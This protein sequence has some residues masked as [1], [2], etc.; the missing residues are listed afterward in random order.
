MLLAALLATLLAHHNAEMNMEANVHALL[1]KYYQLSEENNNE[2][3]AL[4]RLGEDSRELVRLGKPLEE[5]VR[6]LDEPT[7]P[8]NNEAQ[9]L[10]ELHE[11]FGDIP[12][13]HIR[14]PDS[15]GGIKRNM[16]HIYRY[17]QSLTAAN[18]NGSDAARTFSSLKQSVDA[19]FINPSLIWDRGFALTTYT[20]HEY[21]SI[22]DTMNFQTLIDCRMLTSEEHVKSDRV[23]QAIQRLKSRVN[24]DLHNVINSR[25][26]QS[27]RRRCGLDCSQN[28]S[29]IFYK[30]GTTKTIKFNEDFL[31]AELGKIRL[32]LLRLV[33]IK[34]LVGPTDYMGMWG[35]PVA[36]PTEETE[37]D[38]VVTVSPA[39]LETTTP[40]DD[41]ESEL[42]ALEKTAK[43]IANW[44]RKQLAY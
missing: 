2:L 8:N 22:L 26:L 17:M 6:P 16:N 18:R 21:E 28:R 35:P 30:C 42:K 1:S 40:R 4:D 10:A 31:L 34:S 9:A 41:T 37:F 43:N 15:I 3:K 29:R 11:F 14:E 32:D 25:E 38:S 13:T 19:I 5:L 20:I 23:K 36:I 44:A 27:S 7:E 33:L 12:Y 24:V 39:E